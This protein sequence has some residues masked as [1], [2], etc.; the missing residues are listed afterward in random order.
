MAE[1]TNGQAFAF[2]GNN[3]KYKVEGNVLYL[4]VA[5]DADTLKQ[6]QPSKSSGKTRTVATTSGFTG[7]AGTP[8]KV[9][10][11]VSGPLA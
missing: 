6:A 8:V 10:L 11:N 4:A 2:L 3:V 9:S 7:V 1:K 5:I